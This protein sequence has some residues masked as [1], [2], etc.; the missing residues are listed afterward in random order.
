MS[1]IYM[2]ELLAAAAAA[3]DGCISNRQHQPSMAVARTKLFMAL[4]AAGLY[5]KSAFKVG[6]CAVWVCLKHLDAYVAVQVGSEHHPASHNRGCQLHLSA[7]SDHLA[8]CQR[9]K[10]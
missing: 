5:T 8:T 6:S 1:G 7:A 9:S 2:G 3:A 4:R 10:C